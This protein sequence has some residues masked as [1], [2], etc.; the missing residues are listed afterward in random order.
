MVSFAVDVIERIGW[1]NFY[2]MKMRER[3]IMSR[4]AIIL[5]GDILGP[6]W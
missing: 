5:E 6:F 1:V 2:A 3:I 4:L